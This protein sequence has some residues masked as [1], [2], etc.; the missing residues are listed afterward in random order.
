MLSSASLRSEQDRKKAL[1]EIEVRNTSSLHPNKVLLLLE[2]YT[3]AS[4][5]VCQEDTG[6]TRVVQVSALLLPSDIKRD[7]GWLNNR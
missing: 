2:I 5:F 1:E 6:H 4:S 3:E 7:D